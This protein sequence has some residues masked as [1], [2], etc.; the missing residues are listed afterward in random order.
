MAKG[1]TFNG[2]PQSVKWRRRRLAFIY[3]I[4]TLEFKLNIKLKI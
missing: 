2:M 1:F 3:L 4:L